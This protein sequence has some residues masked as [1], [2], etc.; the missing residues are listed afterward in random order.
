MLQDYLNI[1]YELPTSPQREITYWG[2]EEEKHWE[3]NVDITYT[4]TEYIWDDKKPSINK[5]S[6][7]KKL[8]LLPQFNDTQKKQ[9]NI[10]FSKLLKTLSR[11][12]LF[13]T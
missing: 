12:K 7:I 4:D 2:H 11:S 1:K 13:T 6:S 3:E 8:D 5:Y 10:N 9:G